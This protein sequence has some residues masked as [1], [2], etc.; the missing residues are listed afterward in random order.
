MFEEA[1]LRT[2]LQTFHMC[3]GVSQRLM[4]KRSLPTAIEWYNPKSESSG[5]LSRYI[6][7]DLKGQ[8]D[9]LGLV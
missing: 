8:S 7:L 3:A 2:A 9:F 1:G 4:Q 6:N 5:G